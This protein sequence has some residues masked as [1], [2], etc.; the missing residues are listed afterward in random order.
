MPL[1]PRGTLAAVAAMSCSAL[2][3][4]LL[5]FIRNTSWPMVVSGVPTGQMQLT[6]TLKGANSAASDLVRP[7]TPCLA[8]T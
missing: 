3:P 4:V 6:V 1:R 5:T 7:M 2:A 8:A